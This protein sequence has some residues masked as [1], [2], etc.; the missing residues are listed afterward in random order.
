[1]TTI[2]VEDPGED[3]SRLVERAMTGDDVVISRGG[4]PVAK[5]VRLEDEPRPRRRLGML[6][7]Q[8]T[9]TLDFDDPL[10]DDVLAAF[11]GR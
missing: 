11:E 3:L 4:V 10:P 8:I 7:G 1:M 5:L 6:E 9:T 2:D